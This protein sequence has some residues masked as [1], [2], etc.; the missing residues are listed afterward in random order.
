MSGGMI[1]RGLEVEQVRRFGDAVR[2]TGLG[3]GINLLGAP[4]E[5]GKSTLLAAL[6]A[7][8]LLA[9]GSKAGPVAALQ[10][11]GGRGAPR[12]AV[13]FTLDGCDW[14]LEKRFMQRAFARLEGGSE[15]LDGDAA[16]ARLHDLLGVEAGR[17]GTEAMGLLNALW[18]T[19]G[20]SLVQPDFSDPARA[21]IRS[22]LEADLDAMTGGDAAGRVL[23][24]VD[25]DLAVLVD[26]RD[27]PRGRFR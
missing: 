13:D 17:R 24:R 9:H 27:N 23:S 4:N 14:R 25:A 7:V 20:H 3:P 12:I 26:K 1:L 18:V 10:P 21:T 11:Y 5:F 6:R 16:E 19:Q 8:F 15:R 2:L 22:C